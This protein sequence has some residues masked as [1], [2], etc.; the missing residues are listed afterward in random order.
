MV[1]SES[2]FTTSQRRAPIQAISQAPAK[3]RGLT[4]IAEVGGREVS[5]WKGSSHIG[6]ISD[7]FTD[8]I[9]DLRFANQSQGL[10]L[11]VLESPIALDSE[12]HKEDEPVAGNFLRIFIWRD[13]ECYEKWQ[14]LFSIN[15]D[16][17]L[18]HSF[19]WSGS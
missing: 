13:L 9:E 15:I 7:S 4:A 10:I 2:Q 3:Y 14:E 6:I 16:D 1:E 17:H 19:D 8:T 12:D 11:A 18:I 5:I